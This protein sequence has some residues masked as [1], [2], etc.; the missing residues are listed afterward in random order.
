MSK[1]KA[2]QCCPEITPNLRVCRTSYPD[3]FLNSPQIQQWCR[4][5]QEIKKSFQLEEQRGWT[6]G[7][8]GFWPPEVKIRRISTDFPQS[9]NGL[10]SDSPSFSLNVIS[11]V[12]YKLSWLQLSSKTHSK[13]KPGTVLSF[14]TIPMIRNSSWADVQWRHNCLFLFPIWLMVCCWSHPSPDLT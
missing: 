14:F 9:V 1:S 11:R 3:V 7:R 10:T 8:C 6:V 13:H 12:D 5:H 2:R 4:V